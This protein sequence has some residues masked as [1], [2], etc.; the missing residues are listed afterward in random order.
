VG[1]GEVERGAV[2]DFLNSRNGKDLP[3][4]GTHQESQISKGGSQ[5][6]PEEETTRGGNRK[7]ARKAVF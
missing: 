2:A 3:G 4:R 7:A 5:E 6:E 1:W